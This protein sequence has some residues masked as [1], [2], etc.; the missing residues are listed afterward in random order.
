[1]EW[2]RTENSLCKHP[3]SIRYKIERDTKIDEVFHCA[4]GGEYAKVQQE[5]GQLRQENGGCEHG[6]DEKEP[7]RRQLLVCVGCK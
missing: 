7:L 3:Y 4:T 1:M 2:E 6:I 5:Q